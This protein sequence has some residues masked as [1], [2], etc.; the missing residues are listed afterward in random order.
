M[1]KV[2]IIS[3][4]Y[5]PANFV[6]GER[7]AAWAKHL[8]DN[9]IYPIIITRQWNDNQKDLTDHVLENDLQIE[10]FDHCEIIRLPFKKSLRDR[11]S[12]YP[13]LK[14]LQKALTLKELIFSNFFISSLP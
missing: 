7:T 11:L 2:L 8:A 1:K 12:K 10:K 14:P 6:G 4:F 13:W 3:Y 5:P 9:D